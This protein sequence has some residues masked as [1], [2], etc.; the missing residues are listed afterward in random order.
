MF[1]GPDLV[2][3]ALVERELPWGAVAARWHAAQTTGTVAPADSNPYAVQLAACAPD[4]SAYEL[5]SA[6]LG[7]THGALT[8]ALVEVLRSPQV[9]GLSWREVIEV[10]RPAVL[11]VVAGQRPDVLGP[12]RLP[13]PVLAGGEG[14][15]R[16]A[17]GDDRGRGAV[18][19]GG[20]AVRGRGGRHLPAARTW[21]AGAAG[22]GRRRAG[23]SGSGA[24]S[25]GWAPSRAASAGA[26][27]APGAGQHGTP[28]GGRVA[29]GA[30]GPRRCRRR[31]ARFPVGA[32]L[33]ADGRRRD[34][35]T[36]S[37]T[38]TASC[39]STR[40][41]SRCRPSAAGSTRGGSAWSRGPWSPWRGPRT[42]ASWSPATTAAPCRP[43]S[44]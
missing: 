20:R 31:P 44:S 7:G 43:T 3:R 26:A 37:S 12:E 28:T 33:G 17:V 19:R 2:P 21:C 24:T 15:H 13:L 27:R 39:C 29:A 11:D 32:G 16:G 23:L 35:H 5:P 1:R 6:T 41:D 9:G 4:Q 10:V 25:S 30:P 42:C 40:P 14:R 36:A 38:T 8:A 34:G 18:D 22:G